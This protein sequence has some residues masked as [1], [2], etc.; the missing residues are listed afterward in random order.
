MIAPTLDSQSIITYA[1]GM[2]SALQRTKWRLTPTAAIASLLLGLAMISSFFLLLQR[3]EI[4]EQAA[5]RIYDVAMP[6]M[7]DATR[8]VRGLER[9]ARA[10]EGLMWIEDINQRQQIRLALVSIAEDGVL[11]GDPE[12]RATIQSAFALLDENLAAL[13][14]HGKSARNQC[15]ERWKPLA[16]KLFDLSEVISSTASIAAI[17]EAERIIEAT[18]D[19]RDR[20]LRL[21]AAM[22]VFLA[23]SVSM[24]MWLIVRPLTRL[25]RS[26]EQAQAGLY[27]ASQ[28][29]VFR[30][31]QVVADAADALAAGHRALAASK[32]QLEL[33]AHTDVLTGLANRRR[34]IA[35]AEN[36]LSRHDRYGYVTSL[37]MFDLD[38]FKQIND[39]YGHD[40]GD[41]VLRAIGTGLVG[42]VRRVDLLAR[43]GGEEF[44]VLLP[45]QGQDVAM[46][47]AQRLRA[48]VEAMAISTA[49][50]TA[51]RFT[52]SFGVAEHLSGESLEAFMNRA[53][54]ALY[55]AKS[56][57]RNRVI[58]APSV[59]KDQPLDTPST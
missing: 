23:V 44:A 14:Q 39:R 50:H 9:L 34:F 30:E 38:N 10:G 2:L 53:D 7:A 8:M 59:A 35:T 22:L 25:S 37:I 17:D 26:L 19:S 43:I 3:Q 55:E 56:T 48:A 32:E 47:S 42:L 4:I 29:E 46:L 33:M 57:G 1:H 41:A 45:E 27:G 28:E 21:A 16:Q 6:T 36:E 58:V 18:R 40:G 15:L 49:T 20:M 13:A 51:I 31:F 52:A 54:M 12:I 5:D 24:L 11:Q